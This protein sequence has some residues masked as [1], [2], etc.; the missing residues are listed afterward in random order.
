MSEPRDCD[1][2][3]A[4]HSWWLLAAVIAWVAIIVAGYLLYSAVER[5]IRG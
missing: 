2:A 4:G 3:V 1:D 5:A